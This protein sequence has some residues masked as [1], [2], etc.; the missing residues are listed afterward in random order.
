MSRFVRVGDTDY[1]VKVNDSGTITFD[2]GSK[3][4]QVIIT[5]N[6]LV[7]GVT[8]TI[9]STTTTITDPVIVINNQVNESNVPV[10][11]GIS[12]IGYEAGIEIG[13]G[14]LYPARMVYTEIWR[15]YPLDSQ[16]EQRGAFVF[17]TGDTL[18]AGIRTNSV[19][20]GDKDEDLNLLGPS[21]APNESGV[22][23]AVVSVA[24]VTNYADRINRRLTIDENLPAYNS[25]IPNV[26]WVNGALVGYFANNPPEFIQRDNSVLRIFDA[27]LSDQFGTRLELKLDGVINATFKSA[28]FTVQDLKISNG[29]IETLSLGND[30]VLK[31]AS[32]GSVT[33]GDTVDP[34]NAGDSLRIVLTNNTP[35]H[36]AGSVK[37]YTKTENY[38]GTGVYFVNSEATRD[39][40]VSRRKALAYSM[41]F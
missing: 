20:T 15:D 3:I 36:A 39:E 23:N 22:G 34:A 17:K 7:E 41:I 30:L 5:G 35:V 40:L 26:E 25:A 8:T 13:R 16:G 10:G 1:K 27:T 11:T 6:L 2:T 14:T 24:D 18:L 37:L 4:G 31:S 38:G 12:A 28:E 32:S 19:T 33:I 9:E 29:T 21:P